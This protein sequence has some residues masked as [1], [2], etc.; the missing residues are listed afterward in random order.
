[1]T[2]P[3]A[4][5]HIHKSF[6]NNK[7]LDN[8]SLEVNKGEV[9]GLIGLNGA[10]KTTLIKIILGLLNAD[11][12]SIRIN[13]KEASDLTTRRHYAYLPEKFHPS[14]YLKGQE[15]LSLTLS[16]YQKKYDDA[17]ARELMEELSLDP[18]VIP[19]KMTKYSKGMGQKIGLGSAFLTEVP[20][21][22][23][24]EP[25]S[26]LDPQAR[27]ALKLAIKK[28]VKQKRTVFFSS[29][30]LSDIDEICDRIAIIHDS[31]L[32]FVG[33]PTDFKKEQKKRK[34]EDA[35]LKSIAA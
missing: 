5:Q 16:Y 9:F 32:L 7:V 17:K 25:M 6:G 14:A 12:G 2:K 31:K 29:H 23:L 35:F 27:I 24:D 3:L 28:Y 26:G 1:M 11:D 4:I 33:T 10:G 13:D 34:L 8:I 15:F 18:D 22:I 21:L 20:L 30:I 19:Q